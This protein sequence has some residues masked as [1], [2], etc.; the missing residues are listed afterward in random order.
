[1]TNVTIDFNNDRHYCRQASSAGAVDHK[2]ES[3]ASYEGK[4]G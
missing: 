2:D 1:M 4:G 3:D